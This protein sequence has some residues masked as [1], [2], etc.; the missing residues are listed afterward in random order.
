M[1]S[2]PTSILSTFILMNMF[3]FHLDSMSLMGLSL[4]IGILGRRL[5][6]RARK[7]HATSRSRAKSPI[8]AAI[9]GRSEIGGAA[10]AIT[11]VDVVVFLP[12]AFLPGIVGAYLKEFAAVIVVATLF[13][14]FVSFTLTPLLAARWSVLHRSLAPPK[15]MESLRSLEG[16]RTSRGIAVAAYF[17][18]WPIKELRFVVPMMIVRDAAAE[19]LRQELRSDSRHGTARSGC[20]GR[21]TTGCS[22]SGF[23]SYSFQ[24]QSPWLRVRVT[25]RSSARSSSIRPRVAR[26]VG[27]WRRFVPAPWLAAA[28]SHLPR[29]AGV[30]AGRVLRRRLRSERRSNFRALVQSHGERLTGYRCNVRAA[31]RARARACRCFR[32]ATI[33]RCDFVPATQTGDD[34]MTVTYPPG[35]PIAMTQKFVNAL[36]KAS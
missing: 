4:I 36:E 25:T 30:R 3:G 7:Y 20:R 28:W 5:D 1:V 31:G 19:S 13:S 27:S 11:M 9:N 21:S 23:A 6:R 32:R 12:V 26:R 16:L 17:I 34:R 8:D 35:T 22:S 29:S 2:I 10:V 33:V 14:L 15:W 24:S 18:P